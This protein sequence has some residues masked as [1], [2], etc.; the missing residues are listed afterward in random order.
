VIG[1]IAGTYS[2]IY[3]AAPML[4]WMRKPVAGSQQSRSG[5][6]VEAGGRNA[7]PSSFTKSSGSTPPAA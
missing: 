3:I 6:G 1:G 4:L 2:S 7:G 5:R